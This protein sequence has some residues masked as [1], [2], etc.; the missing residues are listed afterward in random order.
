QQGTNAG[1]ILGT[2]A[3]MSPEQARG[4]RVDK[5][6]DIWSFGVVGFEMLTGRRLFAG[7]TVSDTLAAVLR[8]DIPWK[9]LPRN[10]DRGTRRT[11]E[12]CLERDPKKRLRDIGE[13]RIA[14]EQPSGADADGVRVSREAS[15]TRRQMLWAAG[16]GVAGLLIGGAIRSRPS[17]DA[18]GAIASP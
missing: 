4:K 13:A 17:P 5:R 7:E 6:A 3:Y 11:I 2:A 18:S 16:S 14:L 9:A 10:L 12:R 1:V 8:E 15:A